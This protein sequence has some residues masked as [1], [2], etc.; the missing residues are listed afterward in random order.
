MTENT[1]LTLTVHKI[2]ILF[3]YLLPGPHIRTE[4][5]FPAALQFL[6]EKVSSSCCKRKIV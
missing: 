4:H 6:T 2:E 3:L 1:A 5:P